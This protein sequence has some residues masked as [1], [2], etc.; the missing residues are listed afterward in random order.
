MNDPR[1]YPLPA[2]YLALQNIP[3]EAL[4]KYVNWIQ[5]GY[6][7]RVKNQVSQRPKTL[8]NLNF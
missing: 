4:P 1:I 5:R 6:V 2:A 3:E 8:V 7:S